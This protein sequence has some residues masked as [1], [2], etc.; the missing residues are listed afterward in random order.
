METGILKGR[1][2]A[3]DMIIRAE[4]MEV[5]SAACRINFENAMVRHVTETWPEIAGRLGRERVQTI[6]HDGIE[7]AQGY[8]ITGERGVSQFIDI[9]FRLSPTFDT[10]LSWAPT[11]L[12]D[13]AL[14]ATEKMDR[15]STAVEYELAARRLG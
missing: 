5:F 15:V 2:R 10:S 8:G 7:R 9:L 14:S 4:Q 1:F 6:V 13:Q 11:I 12:T 3:P